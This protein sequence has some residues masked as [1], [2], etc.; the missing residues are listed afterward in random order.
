MTGIENFKFNAEQSLDGFQLLLENVDLKSREASYGRAKEIL[1]KAVS[2][3]YF[4]VMHWNGGSYRIYIGKSVSIVGR[5]N[6]YTGK[7]Q[8]QSPNNYKMH[9]FQDFMRE[10]FPGSTL[11]LYYQKYQLTSK[12]LHEPEKALI[13]QFDPLI[14]RLETSVDSKNLMQEA[15]R[16]LYE[17]SFKQV[18][19][20]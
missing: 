2:G 10:N 18:L 15:F 4:W 1:S 5:L 14:N 9:Y 20:S 3:V 19:D 6:N 11:D 8:P 7:F 13:R 12:E 17:S 16:T